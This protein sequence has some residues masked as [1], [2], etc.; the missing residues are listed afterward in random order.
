MQQQNK[1]ITEKLLSDKEEDRANTMQIMPSL[2]QPNHDDESV[3]HGLNGSMN[4]SALDFTEQ[5]QFLEKQ[6]N[7]QSLT[8]ENFF[9]DRYLVTG[10]NKLRKHLSI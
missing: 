1:G 6:N 5:L 2:T 9:L 3:I 10:P 4:G 8:M 7:Q